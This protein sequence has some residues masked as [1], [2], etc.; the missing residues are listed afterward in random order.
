MVFQPVTFQHVNDV[1]TTLEKS[2]ESLLAALREQLESESLVARLNELRLTDM[3]LLVNTIKFFSETKTG[4]FR[5]SRQICKQI[6]NINTVIRFTV[7]YKNYATINLKIL[8]K[9]NK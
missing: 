3:P 1:V 9:N 7:H 2:T 5:C 8:L 4:T 6:V